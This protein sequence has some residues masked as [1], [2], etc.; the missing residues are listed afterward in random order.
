MGAFICNNCNESLNKLQQIKKHLIK[1]K[2]Y[3]FTCIDC[4]QIIKYKNVRL[5]LNCV[6]GREMEVGIVNYIAMANKQDNK[7]DSME[8]SSSTTSQQMDISI[9]SMNT[10]TNNDKKPDR[11]EQLL[12]EIE[13]EVGQKEEQKLDKKKGFFVKFYF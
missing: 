13:D 11:M 12:K 4:Q 2:N 10:S 7:N 8:Q 6:G 9:T 1:C 5:H 3:L